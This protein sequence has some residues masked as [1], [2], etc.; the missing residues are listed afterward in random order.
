MSKN[1]DELMINLGQM[2]ILLIGLAA[3]GAGGMGLL[4][5]IEHGAAKAAVEAHKQGYVSIQEFHRQLT[6]GGK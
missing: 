4:K 2:V 3:L 5:E 6:Q 1:R